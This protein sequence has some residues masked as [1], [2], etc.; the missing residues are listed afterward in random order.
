MKILL[1]PIGRSDPH[2]K[3]DQKTGED[4][5]GSALAICAAVRPDMVILLPTECADGE[6]TRRNAEETRE[7]MQAERPEIEVVIHPVAM[8]LPQSYEEAQRAYGSVIVA[9]T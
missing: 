9:V 2:G 1:S 8:R 5:E 6:D 4:T 3:P 7:W